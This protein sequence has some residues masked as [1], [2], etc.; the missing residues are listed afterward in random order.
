MRDG[1]Y[2]VAKLEFNRVSQNW[3]F[4]AKKLFEL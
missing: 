2:W 4:A 1:V 3:S